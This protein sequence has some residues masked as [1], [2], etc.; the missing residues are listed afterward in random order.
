MKRLVKVMDYN[1]QWSELFE[2]EKRLILKVIGRFVVG[3]EHVGSTAVIGLG[4][5]PIIDITVAIKNLKDA[6][7]CIEPLESIGYEYAPEYEESMPERRYFH[8]GRPPRERH[9]DLHMVELLS[10]FCKRHLLFHNYLRAH[11]EVAQ[12]YHELKKRLAV[13]YGSDHE[14]YTEAKTSFIES[15]VAKARTETDARAI[16]YE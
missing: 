12:D 13:E 16:T 3:I 5:K 4:A 10:D 7:K 1:P 11:P 2:N 14:C 8:K 15:V 6:N 9:Y